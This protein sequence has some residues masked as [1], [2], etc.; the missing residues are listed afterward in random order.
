MHIPKHVIRRLEV[1]VRVY[2][3]CKRSNTKS[4]HGEPEES[5]KQWKSHCHLSPGQLVHLVS[6][7][8]LS[9]S[10]Q[11]LLMGLAGQEAGHV[12]ARVL[13]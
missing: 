6:S 10:F 4:H 13:L 7:T 8:S 5:C 12:A 9:E 1:K 3:P 2:V 11:L